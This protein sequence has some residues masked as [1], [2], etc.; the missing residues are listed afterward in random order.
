MAINS[1]Y[2]INLLPNFRLFA[3]FLVNDAGLQSIFTVQ[4]RLCKWNG[5]LAANYDIPL[6]VHISG[7]EDHPNGKECGVETFNKLFLSRDIEQSL[8]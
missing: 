4:D 2:Y 6:E 7:R 5:I 1:Q 8:P 3:H